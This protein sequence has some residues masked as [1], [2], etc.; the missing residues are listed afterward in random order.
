[1]KQ[2]AF[3]RSRRAV[4][5]SL[6]AALEQQSSGQRIYKFSYSEQ[7]LNDYRETARDLSLAQSRAYSREL[8][9]QLNDLVTRAHN[10]VHVRRSSWGEATKR[11][12]ARDFPREV[13]RAKMF[14]LI[15]ALAFVLPGVAVA[16][17]IAND[18]STIYGVMDSESID[19]IERMYDAKLRKLGRERSSDTDIAM[20]GFYVLNNG[21]IA[22][23]TFAAG[24]LLGLGS[25][26]VL[27]VNGVIISAVI[28]HLVG[29]GSG[30]QILSFVAGH[31]SLELI[32]IVLAGASGCMMGFAL[33]APG[34][35]SRAVALRR[36]AVRAA[37]IILGCVPMLVLAA[38]VEAF[39]SSLTV[40]PATF[41]YVVGLL[42]WVL[43]IA[44]FM[45]V[46]RNAA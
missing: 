34:E 4:W 27:V 43:V 36:N 14:V 13:R 29:I 28:A 39:W 24:I 10:V 1:M 46:G 6:D 45:L 37:R 5:S 30:E 44:Y 18:P 11:F 20:F 17:A 7:F 8:I 22:L 35:Y 25:I 31:S 21:G 26:Y 23:R 42:L 33:L 32:A 15:A 3:E 12:F 9:E 38:F 16:T 40:V 19:G 2:D 41:K